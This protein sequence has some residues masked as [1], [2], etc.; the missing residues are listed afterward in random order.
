MGMHSEGVI[1]ACVT[2]QG[3]IKRHMNKDVFISHHFTII[4]IAIQSI[5]FT[6]YLLCAIEDENNNAHQ[7][8]F[9]SSILRPT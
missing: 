6:T 7:I 8:I 9:A 3:G 5:T 4:D 2:I 1:G